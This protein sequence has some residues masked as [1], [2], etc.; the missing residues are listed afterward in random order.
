[1]EQETSPS[2]SWLVYTQCNDLMMLQAEI[3]SRLRYQ[4]HEKKY[5]ISQV[6]Y[7]EV[8]KQLETERY[9]H[10]Q[11][12]SN[13]I[14]ESE[15]LHFSQGE[16]EMLKQQLDREKAT[17][18]KAFGLLNSKTLEETS[19]ADD[20][21]SKCTALEAL[22]NKKDEEIAHAKSMIKSLEKKMERLKAEHKLEKEELTVRMQQEVYM[23]KR[24]I[25][26]EKKSLRHKHK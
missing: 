24:Q 9:N 18:E 23:A 22:C 10:S 20:L 6:D 8:L 13:L 19:K 3:I 17:F 21:L 12:K 7:N 5:V 15:K 25:E 4:L 1:M 16:V 2:N 26:A 14:N 11:T